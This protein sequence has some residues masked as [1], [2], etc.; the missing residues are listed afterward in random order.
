MPCMQILYKWCGESERRKRTERN[1]PSRQ[2]VGKRPSIG[3][4]SST[5]ITPLQKSKLSKMTIQE[6]VVL[7]TLCEM[8]NIEPDRTSTKMKVTPKE[9]KK[10][11]KR[12]STH[13]NTE[14]L[15]TKNEKMKDFMRDVTGNSE[16]DAHINEEIRRESFRVTNRAGKRPRSLSSLMSRMSSTSRQS[17]VSSKRNSFQPVKRS[18]MISNHSWIGNQ[19]ANSSQ[20][21]SFNLENELKSH[22]ELVLKQDRNAQKNPM[23][24]IKRLSTSQMIDKIPDARPSAI[25]ERTTE[26]TKDNNFDNITCDFDN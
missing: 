18:S 7:E 16:K 25:V 21:A 4:R 14:E 12:F 24:L 22:R 9:R 2:S 19:N 11:F 5:A 23:P 8:T 1:R 13:E 10:L 17:L 15:F 26:A 20:F 3:K 6:D